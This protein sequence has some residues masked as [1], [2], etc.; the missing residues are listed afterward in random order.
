M[1]VGRTKHKLVITCKLSHPASPSI[2]TNNM[3]W[4]YPQLFNLHIHGHSKDLKAMPAIHP[5][6]NSPMKYCDEQKLIQ[7]LELKH[8]YLQKDYCLDSGNWLLL[9]RKHFDSIALVTISPAKYVIFAAKRLVNYPCKHRWSYR[10]E[11]WL[12]HTELSCSRKYSVLALIEFK[13]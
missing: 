5:W 9:Q 10:T 3:M 2:F 4:V 6:C 8:W 7:S 12:M 13:W 11:N 1:P